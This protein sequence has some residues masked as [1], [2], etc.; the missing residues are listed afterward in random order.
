METKMIKEHLHVAMLSLDRALASA[1]RQS[2][3]WKDIKKADDQV[4]S[5]WCA[6]GEGGADPDYDDDGNWK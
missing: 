1:S 5:V 4:D 6:L 2:D 3:V